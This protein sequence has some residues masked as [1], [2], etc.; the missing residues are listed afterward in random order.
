MYSAISAYMY[1]LYVISTYMYIHFPSDWNVVFYWLNM[2]RWQPYIFLCPTDENSYLAIMVN[3]WFH[4]VFVYVLQTV[5]PR[6]WLK[7]YMV[8]INLIDSSA[9]PRHQSKSLIYHEA[10]G[11]FTQKGNNVKFRIRWSN[12]NFIW[13]RL[14][15][16]F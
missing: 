7:K 1:M 6:N 15:W 11:N 8:L 4:S 14:F 16:I 5:S 3:A 10:F 13:R 9:L 2:T 12:W